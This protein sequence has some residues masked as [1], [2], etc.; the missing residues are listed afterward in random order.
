MVVGV[1]GAQREGNSQRKAQAG[2]FRLGDQDCKDIKII[3]TNT[4]KTPRDVG[5]V[6]VRVSPSPA[7]YHHG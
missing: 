2:G 7:Q 4:H 1:K 5:L 3:H 6:Y